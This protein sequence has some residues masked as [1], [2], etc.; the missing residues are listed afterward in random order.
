MGILF[1]AGF[2]ALHPHAQSRWVD[3]KDGKF[4]FHQS[5]VS[6]GLAEAEVGSGQPYDVCW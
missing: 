3:L 4:G 6:R 2:S 1:H 5:E